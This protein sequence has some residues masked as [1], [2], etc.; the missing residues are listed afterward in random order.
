MRPSRLVGKRT[1]STSPPASYR[2][3]SFISYTTREEEVKVIKPFIDEYI[4]RLHAKGVEICPVY[5]DGWYLRDRNYD[6][7][8]LSAELQYAIGQSAFTTAFLSPGYLTSKWCCY[9]WHTTWREHRKRE[10]PA[11]DYSILPFCWKKLLGTA[12]GRGCSREVLSEGCFD[13]S[14]QFPEHW[15]RAL[16]DA[17][18]YTF[19]YLNAW[20]P[21]AGLEGMRDVH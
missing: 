9:E 14:S 8:T 10:F 18:R 11:L 4:G 13:L 1:Q 3:H 20:Y 6:D 17:I 7:F 2:W 21:E 16:N 12:S 19:M 15:V 5:Y